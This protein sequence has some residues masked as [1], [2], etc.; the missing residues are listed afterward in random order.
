MTVQMAERQR[1]TPK[2]RKQYAL[3]QTRLGQT[4]LGG[5]PV[6]TRQASPNRHETGAVGHGRPHGIDDRF[7]THQTAGR[8]M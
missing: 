8:R 4:R 6:R 3:V 2:R 7:G 1:K 5:V